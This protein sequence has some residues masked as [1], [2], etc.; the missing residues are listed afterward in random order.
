MYF[1]GVHFLYCHLVAFTSIKTGEF[2]FS[3]DMIDVLT[4]S[5]ATIG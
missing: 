5:F 1:L 3:A 2:S 4:F